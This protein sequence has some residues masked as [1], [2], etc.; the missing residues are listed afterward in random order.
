MTEPAAPLAQRPRKR[1]RPSGERQTGVALE[2]CY[3]L[4]LWLV[5]VL[6]KFPRTQKFLLGDRMQTQ[7]LEVL[8][9]LI[10]A[11]YVPQARAHHLLA[12]NLALERLRFG[13]RLTHDLKHLDMPRYQ[14]GAEQVNEV[15]RL[16]GGWLRSAHTAHGKPEP[17]TDAQDA[18]PAPKPV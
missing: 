5:P 4:L 1:A 7:A 3:R 18:P 13:L 6:E 12:A 14:H 8:D 2:A 10:A 16:V 15:G 9:H 11:T 17:N